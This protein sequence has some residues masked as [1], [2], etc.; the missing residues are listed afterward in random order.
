MYSLTNI[1]NIMK[2]NIV[3]KS[4]AILTNTDGEIVA[5]ISCGVNETLDKKLKQAIKECYVGESVKLIDSDKI[6]TNQSEVLF[7]AELVEDGEE[8]IRDFAL[9]IVVTY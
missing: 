7:S 6:L 8:T 5:I 1:T 9:N 2:T 3:G 4:N